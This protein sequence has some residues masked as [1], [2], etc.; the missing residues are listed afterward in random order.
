LGIAAV[1]NKY[2]VTANTIGLYL[3]PTYNSGKNV[4]RQVLLL[5]HNSRNVEGAEVISLSGLY[6]VDMKNY[7]G[8]I[9]SEAINGLVDIAKG[10]WINYIQGNKELAPVLL[11]LF[12]AG[13]PARHAAV[14]L[15]Q[16]IIREYVKEQKLAKST[17]AD[18]LGKGIAN[19]MFF[20]VEAKKRILQNEKYGFPV[21]SLLNKQGNITNKLLN[22]L[23]V[24]MTSHFK[25]AFD[26]NKL[27]SNI[28]KYAEERNTNTPHK[29]TDEERAAFLHFIEVEGM[30]KRVNDIKH[31]TNFDTSPPANL[32]E[33]QM[34]D[35]MMAELRMSSTFP[36]SVASD[37]MTKTPIGSYDVAAVSQMFARGV[38]QIRIHPVL[39][40]F[41]EDLLSRPTTAKEIEYTFGT[42][43]DAP[44]KFVNEL[45]NDLMSYIFQNA[46]RHF[47]TGVREYK[48]AGVNTTTPIKE[49]QG[50][51]FGAFVK[52]GVLFVDK[53][54]IASDY[55]NN[56]YSSEEYEQ[57]G[58]APINLNA[59]RLQSDYTHFVYER[60]TLRSLYPASTV[61]DNDAYLNLLLRHL[62]NP[63]NIR[64]GESDDAFADRMRLKSYE[65]FLRNKALDNILN[66]WKMFLSHQSYADQFVALREKYPDL[67]TK[68]S[69][70]RNLK[71]D[72]GK[73]G[74]RNLRLSNNKPS[75]D[76]IELYHENLQDLANNSIVKVE[77][78]DENN[79]ISE[80]FARFPLVAF[81]QSGMNS[82]SVMSMNRIVPQ[83]TFLRIMEKPAKDWVE[84][85]NGN[86]LQDYY[87]RFVAENVNKASRSRRKDYLSDMTLDSTEKVEPS[88]ALQAME[89]FDRDRLTTQP[90]VLKEMENITVTD[91]EIREFLQS[92]FKG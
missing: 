33:A 27:F 23:T 18:V 86:I 9:I 52:E 40:T 82:K 49:I 92:C 62:G 20:R 54:Q 85:M 77:N 91:E 69:L 30:A 63:T 88:E 8:D 50:L 10:D 48:G 72:K 14:F 57:R 56:I 22:E 89:Y 76:T 70:M 3:N 79:Y 24:N 46:V 44:E 11:F 17:F 78:V 42:G 6:D 67:V 65:E 66:P 19:P 58:L 16:P 32:Y 35:R 41:I 71:F 53:E 45:R 1:D 28:K 55:K 21:E 31:K 61:K 7:I 34:R 47:D 43:V 4:F 13:V 51:K 39:N 15:A 68:Y 2:N 12:Q 29:F 37:M 84:H 26:E 25:H 74:Y 87:N 60:E 73:T 59:F 5:P 80:F 90:E 81:M 64:E 36:T 38:F 75:K 83:D